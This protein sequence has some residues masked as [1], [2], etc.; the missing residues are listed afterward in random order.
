MAGK[1]RN[2][3]NMTPEERAKYEKRK[4]QQRGPRPAF[5]VY[6]L[7]T[8]DNGRTALEIVAA[9]RD[10]TEVLQMTTKDRSLEYAAF[11]IK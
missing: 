1:P 7:I 2:L 10:A 6:R 3:D 11:E 9:T 8:D 5:L 4:Q